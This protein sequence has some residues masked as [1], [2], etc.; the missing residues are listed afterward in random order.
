LRVVFAVF[1]FAAIGVSLVSNALRVPI[2][3]VRQR[4]SRGKEHGEVSLAVFPDNATAL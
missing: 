4:P 3:P 1:F 2:Q